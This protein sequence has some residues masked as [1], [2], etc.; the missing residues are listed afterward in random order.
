MES[1]NIQVIAEANL[2]DEKSRARR[3]KS[4]AAIGLVLGIFCKPYLYSID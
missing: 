2:S 1:L 4:I 3:A